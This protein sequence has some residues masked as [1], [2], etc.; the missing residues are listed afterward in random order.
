MGRGVGSD[1][2]LSA[3]RANQRT[4]ESESLREALCPVAHYVP[5]IGTYGPNEGMHH[6]KF[7]GGSLVELGSDAGY[8]CEYCGQ[9]KPKDRCECGLPQGNHRC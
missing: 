3:E 4:A 9:E 5:W 1:Q 7:E 8:F 2:D 6:Y